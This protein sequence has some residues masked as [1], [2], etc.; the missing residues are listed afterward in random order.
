MKLP[1]SPVRSGAKE[2][3]SKRLELAQ[4]GRG[5]YNCL[6]KSV[7][8]VGSPPAKPLMIYDGDC[9]FCARWICRWRHSTG[10]NV[11]YLPYQDPQISGRFPEIPREEFQ[12]SVQLVQTDGAVFRGAEAVFHALALN[13]HGHWLLD[14]YQHSPVF[15]RTTEWSYAFVASHR[16]F[17]SALTRL[18]W[19]K[20]VEPASHREVRWIF[21]RLLGII[22]LIAFC[23]LWVQ[24]A[25]LLGSNGILPVNLTMGMAKQAMTARHVGMDRYHLLPTFCWFNTDD[26]FLHVQCAAGTVLALLVII[27]IAPAPCL[28]LLWLVYLSLTSV[29][30]AFLAFQWDNL[31]LETGFLA[32]FF[33]PLQLLPRRPSR[34]TPPSRLVLWL[35]RWL[36]FRLM[37]ESGCVKLLSGDPAW[38]NLTALTVHFETQPLPT[39]L[40][41]YGHQL[42]LWIQK[43]E[44]IVLFG[45]EL[46]VPL[47]IFMPRRPRQVACLAFVVLQLYILLTGNYGFFNL[48]ALALSLTLLDDAALQSL[49]PSRS[50]ARCQAA[51][52]R[53]AVFS[54]WFRAPTE[55]RPP[56]ERNPGPGFRNAANCRS[57]LCWPIQ[58]TLPLMAIVL[59]A[60]FV[61]IFGMFR[62]WL[63]GPQ[64]VIAVYQ[65][66]LPFRS[67]NTY[68]LFAV[69]TTTRPEIIVEGSNDGSN[70]EAYEFKYKPGDLKR[71]PRFVAPHQPRLDWQM[72]FA[73]LGDYRHN[74]WLVNFCIRLL[75][76]SPEVTALLER[77]PFPRSPPRYI[78][79]VVH[80]YHF[81]DPTI[82]RTTG[83]WWRREWKGIYLPPISLRASDGKAEQVL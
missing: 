50:I 77:N 80:E 67:F 55:Q 62:V 66:L 35:F 74:P 22:Y 8:R 13:P 78:R 17:F 51:L 44:T 31:L 37:F 30:G 16:G 38:R 21:L 18:L 56:P 40:G 58:A 32:I 2:P 15:A 49:A 69:M 54:W 26:N 45:I 72:W 29:G 20:H 61:Q 68:G 65:W 60:S 70:W 79:A 36:L 46:A 1:G 42:P 41:W 24:I 81:T 52:R 3:Q 71:R 19:G 10:G 53:S 9:N 83:A 7:L 6:V 14:W 59:C 57:R 4:R 23:S 48:L 34:E 75:Q 27:G 28:F 25:A 5:E 39:W 47:L 76:G 63:P 43:S 11:E 12:S 64:P 73:A 82:L 33:A